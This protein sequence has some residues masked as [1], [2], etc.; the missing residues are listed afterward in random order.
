[1]LSIIPIPAFRDNYIWLIRE[2]THAAVVDPGDAAPVI[3][4]LERERLQLA[5][6]IATHHH[7][8]HVGG[9]LG[10]LARWPVP[11]F[12]P[13]RETIPGRTKPLGEGD[14]IEVPGIDVTFDVLDIPGHTAGHI[15]FVGSLAGAPAVFCGDT[16]F[17]VGCGRLFEGTP[18]EMWSS[19][20]KL[21]ALSSETR[22]YCGHEY[23]LANIRFAL[24]VEPDNRTLIDRQSREEERR[25]RGEP[26]L[27][28]T[29]GDERKTNP[30]L[31]AEVPAVKAAAETHANHPLESAVATFAELRA[32]KNAFQ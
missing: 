9:N 7:N 8:D 5:A 28:S 27:P 6:I 12:G 30:F 21:A 17:A 16:L 24:A 3:A 15:A 13:A 26:T 31:R 25:A 32:W 18:T 1:M 2:G 20:S 10:L 14:C 4:Y 11:V 22:V 23:T 29:I 19:L